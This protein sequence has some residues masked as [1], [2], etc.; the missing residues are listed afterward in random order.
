M[1]HFLNIDVILLEKRSCHVYQFQYRYS[2]LLDGYIYSRP[3]VYAD[4]RVCTRHFCFSFVF[5]EE[6]DKAIGTAFGAVDGGIVNATL[7]GG[8]TLKPGNSR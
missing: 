3:C 5:S 8:F 7:S 1:F 4:I 6:I 2:A